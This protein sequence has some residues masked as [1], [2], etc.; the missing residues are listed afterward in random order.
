MQHKVEA[1]RKADELQRKLE[2][3]RMQDMR[4]SLEDREARARKVC[5]QLYPSCLKT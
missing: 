4:E 5:L 1:E 3:D 2:K